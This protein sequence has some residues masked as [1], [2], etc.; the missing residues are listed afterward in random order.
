MHME[1]F[2]RNEGAAGRGPL[3][4]PGSVL[5]IEPMLTLGSGNTVVF[6]DQWTVTTVDGSRAAHW[7][8][9]VAVTEDGPRIL[10]LG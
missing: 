9:T 6:D 8:H 7:E 4:A 1:P 10:T 2:L 5:A 3:L